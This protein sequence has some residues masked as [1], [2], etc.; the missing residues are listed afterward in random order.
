MGTWG[1]AEER[2][3]A[4]DGVIFRR[5]GRTIAESPALAMSGRTLGAA[6]A[7]LGCGGTAFGG[8]AAAWRRSSSCHRREPRIFLKSCSCARCSLP[9]RAGKPGPVA[10]EAPA[11]PGRATDTDRADGMAQESRQPGHTSSRGGRPPSTRSCAFWTRANAWPWPGTSKN[12]CQHRTPRAGPRWT[13]SPEP[14][15]PSSAPSSET[16]PCPA[17]CW[18]S[19]CGTR[20]WTP[21]QVSRLSLHLAALGVDEHAPDE[22]DGH[23]ETDR[24]GASAPQSHRIGRRQLSEE[25]QERV[26]TIASVTIALLISGLVIGGLLWAGRS[27]HQPQ[28]PS[29]YGAPTSS[30]TG[31]FG[32]ARPLFTPEPVVPEWLKALMPS[33]AS[34]PPF[35]RRSPGHPGP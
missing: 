17:P 14:S 3:G 28:G 35:A 6:T 24:D 26:T 19:W 30:P 33:L 12:G 31:P 15:S 22:E 21:D 1:G 25:Q 13:S 11:A 5:G 2:R 16:V 23:T 9:Q 34:Q 27:D 7:C 10:M 8:A 29:R 18:N 32:P 20:C 4:A